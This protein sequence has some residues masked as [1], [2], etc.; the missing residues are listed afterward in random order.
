MIRD[1]L[2]YVRSKADENQLSLSHGN[3]KLE[4]ITK[5]T[6]MLRKKIVCV[7]SKRDANASLWQVK[8]IVLPIPNSG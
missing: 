5:K 3:R 4:I 1:D 7:P 2:F 6:D 8:C